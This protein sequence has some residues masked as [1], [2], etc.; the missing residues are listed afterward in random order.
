MHHFHMTTRFSGLVF[1]ASLAL[2]GCNAS[3]QRTHVHQ[4]AIDQPAATGTHATSL[5][6]KLGYWGLGALALANPT[7]SGPITMD[8]LMIHAYG[9]GY[10]NQGWDVYEKPDG[11][12]WAIMGQ[13]EGAFSTTSYYA[14][15]VIDLHANAS[16]NWVRA[17]G[18][19]TG[20]SYGYSGALTTD[21]GYIVPISLAG[22]SVSTIKLSSQGELRWAKNFN[23]GNIGNNDYAHAALA[24][25][26]GGSIVASRYSTGNMWTALT[27]FTANGDVD[28]QKYL[29]IV[30][31]YTY[32]LQNTDD[33][34]FV[35]AGY[36]SEA[37][38]AKFNAFGGLSW[39]KEAATTSGASYGQ[40]VAELTDGSFVLTGY[41][42]ATGS[43]GDDVMAAKFDAYGNHLWSKAI[44]GTDDDFGYG[45]T[46]TN[47]GNMVIVGKT[48]SFDTAFG[49]S[50]ALFVFK[51]T[52]DGDLMWAR[53]IGGGAQDIG[54]RVIER[55]NGDLVITGDSSGLSTGEGDALL[56]VM[57]A[58]GHI[59]NTC[60]SIQTVSPTV[61][62]VTSDVPFDWP[63]SYT[64][65]ELA[66]AH[67]NWTNVEV[68]DMTDSFNMLSV[69]TGTPLPSSYPTKMPTN[70][71][72][73]AP[74]LPT[75]GPTGAPSTAPTAAPS[76]APTDPTM[77]PTLA[78]T[79][80]PIGLPT[81]MPTNPT[82][83]PTRLPSRAPVASP[84]QMPTHW[85]SA[86]PTAAPAVP[87]ITPTASPNNAANP[88]PV[89]AGDQNCTRTVV[90]DC[91]CNT[92]TTV[93]S[94][95][96]SETSSSTADSSNCS[97][98]SFW[99]SVL[100][101][102]VGSFVSITL[103][104]IGICSYQK[105]CAKKQHN[106]VVNEQELATLNLSKV[107]DRSITT[108]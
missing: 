85:P 49:T 21:G 74:I 62:N 94:D 36:D 82:A 1:C 11:N 57:S 43:G 10:D 6:K 56:I 48:A 77:G 7:S 34:G 65:G 70:K 25:N 90:C 24:T 20:Q 91:W 84:T 5:L 67:T 12:G 46:S 14:G 99:D 102:A 73:D 27:K 32:G 86:Q 38:I 41:Y 108:H 44:G 83:L 61:L 55:S 58:D 13:T 28:W 29:R 59:L 19:S 69:C 100:G 92:S 106:A 60:G 31:S 78:P 76:Q 22:V 66:A 105:G 18:R 40:D 107:G 75:S 33:G 42:T 26:D 93:A 63:N 51:L 89:Q 2:T 39:L 98:N 9:S 104:A 35:G 17:V 64:Y 15:M 52:S 68:V 53:V 72:T 80:A 45:I 4:H 88:T 103:A 37:Y 101:S 97:D 71:P 47:D 87:V 79:G 3:T 8:T 50:D 23:P 81:R 30:G 95:Q 16:I 96:V 54:Y